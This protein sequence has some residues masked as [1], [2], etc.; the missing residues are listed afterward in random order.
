M[1]GNDQDVVHHV[2]EQGGV[3][4]NFGYGFAGLGCQACVGVQD[5]GVGQ[6]TR[7]RRAQLVAH[8]GEELVLVGHLFAQAVQGHFQLALLVVQQVVEHHEVIGLLP[9][10]TLQIFVEN[11]QVAG[12]AV[13]LARELGQF[14]GPAPQAATLRA[15]R[16]QASFP[17]APHSLVPAR[18]GVRFR[19]VFPG[20]GL[21]RI[22][23]AAEIALA[24]GFRRR[25]QGIDGPQHQP[26]CDEVEPGE[27]GHHHE[28]HHDHLLHH[29]VLDA[30]GIN[31]HGL[32]DGHGTAHLPHGH[33][34]LRV[35]V[36]IRLADRFAV[37]FQA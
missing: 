25:A 36:L 14:V 18:C 28:Q 24:H 20:A 3:R 11:L 17:L 8:N 16:W 21:R 33:A 12:H 2:Q 9:Y 4:L 10:L 5:A 35:A 34:L 31:V 1:L 15:V 13:E 22:C 27:G 32:G 26:A 6:D 19:F 29:A 37:A 23:A 30:G 7:E